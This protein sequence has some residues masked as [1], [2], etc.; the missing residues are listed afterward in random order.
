MKKKEIGVKLLSWSLLV[1]V[2]L[3]T[4]F[5]TVGNGNSLSDNKLAKDKHYLIKVTFIDVSSTNATGDAWDIA[6]GPDIFV[7]IKKNNRTIFTSGV[8]KNTFT[9]DFTHG[10][11]PIAE[12][13]NKKEW[14]SVHF[15]SSSDYINIYIYDSDVVR[16]DFIGEYKI[17][18]KDLKQ[19]EN[20][21]GRVKGS[22]VLLMKL[23]VK[24]LEKR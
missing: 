17:F 18:M 7:E 9:A 24:P 16:N 19:G 23:L 8:R 20:S 6:T 14:A 13:I 5:F 2:V 1:I 10:G 11:S 4:I 3:I 15:M 21:F 22:S 12:L